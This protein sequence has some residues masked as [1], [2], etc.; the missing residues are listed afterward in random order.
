M[1]IHNSINWRDNL[2]LF[3]YRSV[4]EESLE[5]FHAHD[6]LEILYIHEGAGSYFIENQRYTLQP[7]TLVLIKPF[8]VHKLKVVVPPNY[9]RSLLKIKA[10]VI[11]RFLTS[12]PQLAS[13]FNE[14]MAHPL[15]NQ[16]FH[17]SPNEACYFENQFLQLHELLAVTAS[18]LQKEVVTLFLFQFFTYFNSHIYSLENNNKR[19]HAAAPRS[20]EPI[21][22]IVK[23]I[24]R[25]YKLS[26]TIND[27][28]SELHFSASYLSKVFKDQMGVTIVEYTNEK[29]LEE[30]RT[31]LALEFLTIEEISR[32]TGFN[33]PSY[34]I[35]MFKKKYG[36][37]PLRYRMS[38]E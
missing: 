14:L 29:R 30:A 2:Y 10:S 34:F 28:A 6:G 21:G 5:Y 4:S 20:T 3:N 17:L 11:E 9:I 25:Y 24:D 16:V 35:A 32:K 1:K 12:L 23:W 33:Y 31:L 19:N 18:K 8:Q 36:V 38:M 27:I 22:A 26:F 15:P 37:T 7:G 13:A